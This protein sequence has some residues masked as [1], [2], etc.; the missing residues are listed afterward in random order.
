LT[1]TPPIGNSEAMEKIRQRML[2][3][4]RKKQFL[5]SSRFNQSIQKIKIIFKGKKNEE[6]EIK[7]D[8]TKMHQKPKLMNSSDEYE[9]EEEEKGDDTYD[10]NQNTLN[11]PSV[12]K[13]SL[14]EK[15][16]KEASLIVEEEK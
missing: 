5:P 8:A 15:E 13:L 11:T 9:E 2:Q 10:N 3:I 7:T 16:I 14:L 6:Q 1:E 12:K 4:T